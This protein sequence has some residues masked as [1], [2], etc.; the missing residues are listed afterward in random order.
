MKRGYVP[1]AG[2]L[3]W[4]TF[5]PQTGR[6]QKGGR[7]A[8]ILSPRVYNERAQLAVACPITSKVKGLPSRSR[9]YP[10]AESMASSWRIT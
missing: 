2:D 5:D 4:V 8:V 7:P 9:S 3:V 1:D 6:E 10:I